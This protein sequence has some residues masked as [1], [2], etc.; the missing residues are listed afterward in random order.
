MKCFN[1]GYGESCYPSEEPNKC[2]FYCEKKYTCNGVCIE[3][4]FDLDNE[5]IVENCEDKEMS[6]VEEIMS[7]LSNFDVRTH[8]EKLVDFGEAVS[9]LAKRM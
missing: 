3:I 1:L 7:T 5:S 6:V 4:E 2:C 8:D 9:Q